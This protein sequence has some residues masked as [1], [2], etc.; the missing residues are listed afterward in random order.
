[1]LTDMMPIVRPRRER[2]LSVLERKAAEEAAAAKAEE[3]QRAA[4]AARASKVVNG[5]GLSGGLVP[6]STGKL[7]SAW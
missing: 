6:G 5:I 1:M 3:L 2:G 4:R 7:P